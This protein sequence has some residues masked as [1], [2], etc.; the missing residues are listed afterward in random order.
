MCP[1]C[2]S[3]PQDE[4]DRV[5][6]DGKLPTSDDMPNLSYVCAC[7]KETLRW[8]PVTTGGVPRL[9]VKSGVYEGRIFNIFILSK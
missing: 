6:S 9:L 5:I 3:R 1:S 8:R 4:L 7:I 2:L